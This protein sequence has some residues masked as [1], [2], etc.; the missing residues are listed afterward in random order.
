MARIG[1][2]LLPALG[3]KI[4]QHLFTPGTPGTY[5]YGITPPRVQGV[6]DAFRFRFRNLGIGGPTLS[7][8]VIVP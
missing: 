6:K 4:A 1:R 3:F 7:D 8:T 5:D 2:G